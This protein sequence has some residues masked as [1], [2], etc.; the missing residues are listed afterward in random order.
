M[1]NKE[2]ILNWMINMMAKDDNLTVAKVYRRIT[3]P[4]ATRKKNRER[5]L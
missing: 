3:C 4:E 2:K 5:I 1:K